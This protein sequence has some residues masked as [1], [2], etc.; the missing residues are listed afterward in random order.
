MQTFWQDLRYG[1]RM[2][3]KQPGFSLVAILTLALGIGANTALFSIVKSV[4]IE[5][6]P[7]AQPERLLQA[8]MT[9]PS[10]AEPCSCGRPV[11]PAHRRRFPC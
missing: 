4:L 8:R 6:L 5:P 3:M 10:R 7:F 2:L 9:S 1:V 11:A